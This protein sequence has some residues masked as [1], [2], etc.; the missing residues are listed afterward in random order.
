MSAKGAPFRALGALMPLALMLAACREAPPAPAAGEQA[1]LSGGSA[2]FADDIAGTDNAVV[3]AVR[4]ARAA[5]RLGDGIAAEAAI[6]RALSAGGDAAALSAPLARA[7]ALQGEGGRALRAL[8]E[9]P[10]VAAMVGE[11]AWVA[12]DV[13]LRNGNLRAAGA[14]YDRALQAMPQN[15]ALWLSVAR[16]RAANADISGADEAASNAVDFD[17]RNADAL[18]LKANLARTRSGLSAALRWYDAALQVNPDH[19]G[20]LIE[21]AAT[22]G[23]MGR[24]RDMLASL[25]RAATLTP[26]EPRLFYLQAVVAARAGNYLLARSLLQRTRGAMDDVPGVMLLN[27]IVEMQLEGEAV[28]A[29]WG[30]RLLEIQPHNRSVRRLLAAAEWADGNAA[31][32]LEALLPVVARPDADSWS[33]LFA[34]R[35]AAELEQADEA[36]ALMTRAGALE[37]GGAP[38]FAPD[39]PYGL[40][41]AAADAAPL[42]PAKVIPAMAAEIERGAGEAAMMR[43]AALRDANRGVADAHLLLG[44]AALAAG[45]I[46][47]ALGAYRSA[48]E[49]DS[50]ERTS[51]RLAYGLQRAGFTGEAGTVIAR[52]LE[53]QP[54]S[55]AAHRIAGA[56]AMAARQWDAAITHYE[57]VRRRMGNRDALVLREL[58]RAWEAKGEVERA[59]AYIDRA[60]RLQ[61]LNRETMLIY[62]RL[63]NKRGDAQAAAD[64]RDKAAQIGR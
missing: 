52:L 60:Y 46:E 41:S 64:L 34:A 58:G 40:L 37:R 5:L 17:R 21:R 59:S 11:A 32:A 30:E 12:G 54:S 25:R 1:E 9:H 13:Y 18:A 8:E 56:R 16:Y 14:A 49:L 33:L 27:M 62:A 19:A 36:A 7:Y 44:D 48:H 39:A 43:A 45:R 35:M 55:L 50:G 20:A 51:L 24:Y 15:S 28:A 23:D 6:R 3:Q 31:N 2:A 61:P 53:A 42:D 22:L 47:V 26:N 10:P 29:T 57:F 38:P 63:M 4:D